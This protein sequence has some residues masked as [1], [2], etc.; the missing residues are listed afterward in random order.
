MEQQAAADRLTIS[1]L[2]QDRSLLESQ[3]ADTDSEVTRL[4]AQLA[5]LEQQGQHDRG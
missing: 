4:R 5:S 1:D 2:Q 3:K